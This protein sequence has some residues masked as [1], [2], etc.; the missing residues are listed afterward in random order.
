MQR[1]T[2]CERLADRIHACFMAGIYPEPHV[3]H[4]IDSTFGLPTRR[5]LSAI[6]RD[7]DHCER[8]A[9][10]ELIFFPG[11]DIQILLEDLIGEGRF[12]Q[13][14]QGVI[15]GSLMGKK[16]V[17]SLYYP[18]G[19]PPVC[20]AAPEHAVG[21]FIAR[22]YIHKRI[23]SR[24]M[25]ALGQHVPED[26]QVP[27][28]VMIRNARFACQGPKAD[29]LETFM[30]RMPA[31]PEAFSDHLAFVLQFLEI[32]PDDM[33]LQDSLARQKQLYRKNIIRAGQFERQ[34]RGRNVETMIMQGIRIPHAD[35]EDDMRKI[36]MLDTVAMALYGKTL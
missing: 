34:R 8:D 15:L 30:R 31:M 5:E 6:I 10:L 7:P 28:R 3:R 2:H 11:R 12:Q 18:A 25:E 21:Q 35:P 1:R 4:Y 26:L 33:P 36:A 32:S 17:A 16:P 13:R 22:L 27:A 9:L 19:G 23:P 24:V 14:D 29:F 20:F